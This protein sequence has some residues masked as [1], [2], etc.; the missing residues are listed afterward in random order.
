MATYQKRIN[1]NGEISYRIRAVNGKNKSGNSKQESITWKPNADMTPKQIEKELQKVM[2]KFE[3]DLK[4]GTNI[5]NNIV[6]K[7]YASTWLENR[8]HKIAP[9][10]FR[11]YSVTI[12]KFNL[13]FG[14]LKIKDITSYAISKYFNRLR[15]VGAN[16]N[17][18]GRL[19]EKTISNMYMVLKD[20]LD[21]AVDDDLIRKNPLKEKS[22]VAPK[23]IKKEICFLEE[24]DIKKLLDI[25]NNEEIKWKT[26][27]TL[28]LYSG[29]RRGEAL[30]LEWSDIDF[31]TGTIK[32]NKIIQYIE[33]I[34][35]IEKLPKT[36]TSIRTIN[37]PKECLDILMEYKYW[38]DEEKLK[39]KDLWNN[40]ITL[41]SADNKEF[42]K[43]NNKIFT[44]WNGNPMF[45]DSIN[46]Y[47]KKLCIRHKLKTFTPHGLRHTYTS[48]LLRAGL[49]VNLVSK[50]LGHNNS[51]TTLN[52]YAHIFKDDKSLASNTISSEINKIL[53]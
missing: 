44:Q 9:A 39:L 6:F 47:I 29:L 13:E 33:E 28:L 3:E 25:L 40:T 23:V 15:Q 17:T 10:T 34:G 31:N 42:T 18:G 7:D 4:N 41:K 53:K 12:N 49:P 19:S 50:M 24:E 27:I 37:V 51:T 45:P 35:I 16:K 5:D 1:K 14:Y 46:N 26:L 11:D 2:I 21:C 20:I 22:F 38:Q 32:I 43:K 8:K 52:I 36:K 30:A 48:I